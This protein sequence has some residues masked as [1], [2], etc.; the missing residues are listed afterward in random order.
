MILR[1]RNWKKEENENQLLEIHFFGAAN[2]HHLTEIDPRNQI[3][4][5]I[6]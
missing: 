5:Q 1:T 6:S 3:S 4:T 2:E